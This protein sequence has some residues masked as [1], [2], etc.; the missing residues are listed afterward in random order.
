VVNVL[1]NLAHFHLSYFCS[2]THSRAQARAYTL[3][4]FLVYSFFSPAPTCFLLALPHPPFFLHPPRRRCMH[5]VNDQIWVASRDGSIHIRDIMLGHKKG[6][7]KAQH[8]DDR[9]TKKSRF[10]VN[11]M[12]KDP[13]MNHVWIGTSDGFVRMYNIKSKK[14]IH[15]LGDHSGGIKCITGTE[16]SL[17][18]ASEDFNIWQRDP[19]N[20]TV[21]KQFVGHTGWV[22]CMVVNQ[23]TGHLWSGSVD[24]IRVWD[25]EVHYS[26]EEKTKRKS[27]RAESIEY[28]KERKK[29]GNR[30]KDSYCVD[31]FDKVCSTCDV[32]LPSFLS[33]CNPFT[34]LS[35]SLLS[36]FL[37]LPISLSLSLSLCVSNSLPHSM[38]L[39]HFTLNLTLLLSGT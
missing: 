21:V 18:T 25:T 35:L 34:S 3:L 16:T 30:F 9:P 17:W 1:K 32:L 14:M 12:W 4:N 13:T 19:A 2:L 39:C 27:S 26:E 29:K 6:I 10:F 31:R 7:I 36:L 24:G 23:L 28:D 37:S 20:G 8:D 15:E 38:L 11:A 33:S 22:H 5:V